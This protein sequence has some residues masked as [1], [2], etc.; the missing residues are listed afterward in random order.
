MISIWMVNQTCTQ[1]KLNRYSALEV[2]LENQNQTDFTRHFSSIGVYM[3]HTLLF[4]VVYGTVFPKFRTWPTPFHSLYTIYNP[5][6]LGELKQFLKY[7][8]YSDDIQLYISFTP[9][10]SA[11]GFQTFHDILSWMNSNTLLLNPPKTE[12]LLIGTKQQR[13]NFSV[14]TDLSLSNDIIPVSSSALNLGFIFDSDMSFSD[15]INSVS[16]SCNF[17]IRDIRQIRHLLPL[18][19]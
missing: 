7:H 19:T 6:W 16:E 2:D 14:L 17:H 11:L 8:V 1:D 9:I 5:S 12:I 3:M 18:S 13:L 15:H 4:H 10:T